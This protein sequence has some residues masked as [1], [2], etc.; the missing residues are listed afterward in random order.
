[1]DGLL[2]DWGGVLTTS[3]IGAFAGFCRREGLSENTVRDAFMGD[4]RPLLE[5]LDVLIVDALREK[6]HATHFGIPQA[7]ALVERVHPRRTYLT[8]VSHHLDYE[9]TNAR[10]PQGVELA[11]DGLRIAY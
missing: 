4:A 3:V 6:P 8:H 5:G 1:M 9:I 11:Y 7:L 2:I 10:L